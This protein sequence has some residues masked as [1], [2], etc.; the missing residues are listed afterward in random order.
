MHV[1]EE[2]QEDDDDGAE[3]E[4]LPDAS[5]VG[6]Q[7]CLALPQVSRGLC[8]RCIR[9]MRCFMVL[10]RCPYTTFAA[11]KD[12][13]VTQSVR[14]RFLFRMLGTARSLRMRSWRPSSKPW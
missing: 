5:M 4:E 13:G 6:L 1:E 2:L 8:E 14:G 10:S 11:S 3:E 12:D 7:D 9:R